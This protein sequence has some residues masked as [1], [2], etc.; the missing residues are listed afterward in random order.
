MTVLDLKDVY[1]KGQMRRNASSEQRLL[2]A[3]VHL[4][5]TAQ[6]PI[7]VNSYLVRNDAL[8]PPLTWHVREDQ[9]KTVHLC[10]AS[11]KKKKKFEEAKEKVDQFFPLPLDR[12][13]RP[14]ISMDSINKKY[15]ERHFQ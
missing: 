3:E 15:I 5:A 4:K 7:Q 14:A 2:N 12:S 8:P 9:F 13:S 11:G 1:E 6:K 10:L